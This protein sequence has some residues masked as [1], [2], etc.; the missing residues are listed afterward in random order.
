MHN[1]YL[2]FIL[3]FFIS[4]CATDP[5]EIDA[6]Y[7]SPLVYKDYDCDQI[8]MEMDHVGRRTHILYNRLKEERDADEWQTG[9]GILLLWP[10]L[11]W[12]EGSDGPE[13]TEYAQLKGEYEALRVNSVKKKV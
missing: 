8:A 7:V 1:I 2:I 12:L 3:I 5:K 13:A 11:F 6:A 10:T 9:V 4:S